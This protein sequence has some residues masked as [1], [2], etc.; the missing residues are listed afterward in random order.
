MTFQ[1]VRVPVRVSGRRLAPHSPGTA[2]VKTGR[3][4]LCPR[5]GLGFRLDAGT[6]HLRSG[7]VPAVL[8]LQSYYGP[9]SQG[10]DAAMVTVTVHSGRDRQ[11]AKASAASDSRSP[12]SYPAPQSR[13][14]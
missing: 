8:P 4:S 5:S 10:G 9:C 11:N 13:C 12:L 2:S 14:Q 6:V 1:G 7:P 3:A